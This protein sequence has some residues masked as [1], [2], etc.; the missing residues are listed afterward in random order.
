MRK[1]MATEEAKRW[2]RPGLK[3]YNECSILFRDEN[4]E[5]QVRRPDRVV[6]E[7][8]HMTVIDFKF[9]KR[10][11]K[12]DKQIS[13]YVSLLKKMGYQAEGHIWYLN[14]LFV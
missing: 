2:F 9:G 10:L 6:R 3:L 4:G 7:G 12:H 5:M 1:A 14:E 13:E 11:P 8:N